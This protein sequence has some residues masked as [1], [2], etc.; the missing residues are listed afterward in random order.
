MTKSDQSKNKPANAIWGGRFEDA[1]ADIME[2]INASIDVDKRL[3]REDIEG[4]K[5]HC[6]MLS[7]Q[8][9][10]SAH[11]AQ[12]ICKGLDT[13]AQEIE[14]GDFKFNPALEDIHMNIENRL[15]ELIGETSGKLHTARSRNDQVATDFRLWVRRACQS[16]QDDVKHLQNRLDKLGA[17]HENSVMSGL[18]HLQVAQPVTLGMHLDAYTQMLDR[19]H[20][21]FADTR[22]RLNECPLGACALAGTGFDIDRYY[23]ARALGFEKPVAN[24]MDAVSARDFASEFLFACAQCGL[25]LSRLAEEIILWSTPQ[26]G[27]IKLSD[28]WSTGS[29]IMPQK[30]NPDAAELIRAKTGVLNGNLIQILTLMK[31]LPLAYNKDMQEDK[32]PVFSSFD[33]LSLSLKA[34]AGMLESAEFDT[35]KM[36]EAAQSGYSTATEVADWL[37]RELDIPFRKAHHITGSIVHLAEKSNKALNELDLED[38]QKIESGITK[39]IFR[40]LCP[41]KAIKSRKNL[42]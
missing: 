22:K 19:D 30:K 2:Q 34:M 26:F 23:T 28:Q 41:Q 13:I 21:R 15:S 5:A 38:L 33:V 25:H 17:D 10:I 4:S 8:K 6:E 20:S 16:I 32:A 31:A 42:S 11:D 29:S 39:D 35:E 1:T 9:I 37:V 24:P 3:W 14:S 18:T 7:R 12:S 40:I 36:K 27:F